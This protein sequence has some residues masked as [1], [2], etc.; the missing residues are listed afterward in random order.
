MWLSFKKNKDQP[1]MDKAKEVYTLITINSYKFKAWYEMIALV[2]LASNKW[3]AEHQQVQ[4]QS[5]VLT[6]V[7]MF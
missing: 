7:L 5:T 2:S 4:E 6:N 3:P 1:V